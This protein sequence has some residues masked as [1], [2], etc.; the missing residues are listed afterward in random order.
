MQLKLLK[1]DC[2]EWRDFLAENEHLIVH[3]PEWKSFIEDTFPRTKAK[4]YALSIKDKIKFITFIDL[5]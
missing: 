5:L 3:T 1:E 2:K 4:Y